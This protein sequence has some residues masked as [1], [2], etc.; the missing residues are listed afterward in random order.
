MEGW[1][2]ERAEF[3][4]YRKRIERERE[5]LYQNA[6]SEIVKKYLPVLDDLELALKNKPD[7]P[8]AEGI[9]LIYKKLQDILESEGVRR[10]EAEG[11][12]FDPNIHEAISQSPSEEHE[13]GIIIEVMR[14]GYMLG[15]KVI[16]PALVR[17]A[18]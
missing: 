6:V 8:W 15:E 18:E 12:P 3:S 11:Q 17:V 5:T 4:N 10:I 9:E 2:R 7:D 1:Q 16:R 13:S 14:Q